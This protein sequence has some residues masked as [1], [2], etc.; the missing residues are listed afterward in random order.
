MSPTPPPSRQQGPASHLPPAQ[1]APPGQAGAVF[2]SSASTVL[3]A[4]DQH[5]LGDG[6]GYKRRISDSPPSAA[7]DNKRANLAHSPQATGGAI[8]TTF[9]FAGVPV[10][11]AVDLVK[12]Y[13]G[14]ERTEADLERNHPTLWQWATTSLDWSRW[15]RASLL[16]ESARRLKNTFSSELTWAL[17]T[18]LVID[19]DF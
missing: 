14:I 11:L 3:P 4:S 19:S 1:L 2:P 6:A 18:I 12:W 17:V 7:A 5:H 16:A 9:T 10:E 8:D 13:T 15:T